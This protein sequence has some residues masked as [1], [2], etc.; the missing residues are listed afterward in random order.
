MTKTPSRIAEYCSQLEP[1]A[2]HTLLV[3]QN[4]CAIFYQSSCFTKAIQDQSNT[5]Q[6]LN[7]GLN[8]MDHII[9]VNR[10]SIPDP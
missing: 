6:I 2:R 5:I 3:W 4:F 7:H 10:Q 8:K 1:L 9:N